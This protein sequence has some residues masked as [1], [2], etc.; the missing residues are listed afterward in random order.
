MTEQKEQSTIIRKDLINTMEHLLK[1]GFRPDKGVYTHE[2]MISDIITET[3][4]LEGKW[5]AIYQ[6][7]DNE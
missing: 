3:C 2:G 6:R 4:F 7:L 5:L 1:A